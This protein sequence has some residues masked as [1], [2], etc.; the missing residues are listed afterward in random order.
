MSGPGR[1][2]RSPLFEHRGWPKAANLRWHGARSCRCYLPRTR[3]VGLRLFARKGAWLVATGFNPWETGSHH[4]CSLSLPPLGRTACMLRRE[5]PYARRLDTELLSP[6]VFDEA[7][8]TV[9]QLRG[10]G[11]A[12]RVSYRDRAG[13]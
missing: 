4:S 5:V 8:D 11:A 7:S 10:G 6:C 9:D 1:R 2:R 12:V 3:E 13:S